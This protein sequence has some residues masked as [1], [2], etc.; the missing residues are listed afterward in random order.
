MRLNSGTECWDNIP[1]PG[2]SKKFNVQ[3]LNLMTFLRLRV[4][5]PQNLMF[6]SISECWTPLG[7]QSAWKA[8]PGE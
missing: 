3:P 6:L 7:P 5:F 4:N 8:H 2:H 1:F